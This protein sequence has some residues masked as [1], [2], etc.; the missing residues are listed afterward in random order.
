LG[1]E[2]VEGEVPMCMA[3]DDRYDI[4]P[5]V[6]EAGTAVAFFD[7]ANRAW[8][9]ARQEWETQYWLHKRRRTP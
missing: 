3:A 9:A 4:E 6:H 5:G 7:E 1:A 8:E 2:G